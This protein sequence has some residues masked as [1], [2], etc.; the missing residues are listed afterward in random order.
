MGQSSFLNSVQ[1]SFD[2]S[3][4]IEN[5]LASIEATINKYQADVQ[6][7]T[8]K[9]NSIISEIDYWEKKVTEITSEEWFKKYL[10]A[11]EKKLQVLEVKKRDLDQRE[12]AQQKVIID[13]TH[14]IGTPTVALVAGAAGGTLAVVSKVAPPYVALAAAGGVA[15]GALLFYAGYRL[16]YAI[17]KVQRLEE[18]INKTSSEIE[19]DLDNVESALKNSAHKQAHKIWLADVHFYEDK[20]KKARENLKV[21]QEKLE[22]VADKLKPLE[23][24]KADLMEKKEA[25]KQKQEGQKLQIK[26]LNEPKSIEKKDKKKTGSSI[27]KNLGKNPHILQPSPKKKAEK[28]VEDVSPTLTIE[29]KV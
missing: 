27:V 23:D 5:R 13:K 10:E 15:L 4:D 1:T 18:E 22:N 16:Y 6:N 28:V 25:E 12:K 17:F 21:F 20:V 11:R 19:D 7:V 8:V 29:A 26:I 3:I 24:E 2:P 9:V 14:A